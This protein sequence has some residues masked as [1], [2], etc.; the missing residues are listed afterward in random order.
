MQIPE[1]YK[2]REQA[3]FKHSLLKAYL[4]RLFMIVGQHHKTI[5]Y[6]DCFAGP[7]QEKSKDL[8]DTSIAISLK[9]IQKCRDGLNK[10]G[11]EVHFKTLFIE[12]DQK[13]YEKLETFLERRQD[14]GTETMPLHGE[15]IA[16][17]QKILDWCGE[18]SFTF[19]FVDPTGWKEAVEL[20]TLEPLLKR[21]N[22]E[23]LITF[24]YDFLVRTHTQKS[25]ENDI[26]EI[27]GEVP[28]T[29]SMSPEKKEE[30]LVSRYRRN[31]KTI[32]SSGG[33]RPRTVSVKVLY[34][35]KDRPIYHLVYLTRHPLGIVKFMEASEQLDLVQRKVRARSKQETRIEKSGQEELFAAHEQ[36]TEKNGHVD[37]SV[38]KE[39][40]LSNLTKRPVTFDIKRLADMMEETG[41]FANDFQ[42]AFKELEKVNRVNNLDVK[43][44]RPVNVVNFEKG[45]RLLR[46]ET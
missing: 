46:L 44:A 10:L 29:G 9:I 34:P 1:H 39:Y 24:M 3:Y 30:H 6:V 14:D 17:R 28:V 12:Q 38:V 21:P 13:A 23:F 36:V 45:E 40:W 25:F 41:W 22:S 5:C 27:F 37:L 31:L 2:G 35:L 18:N 43:R 33:S 11:K 8:E 7:W 4:E 15:F 42:Q 16:S 26:R 20:S 19:F 32:V